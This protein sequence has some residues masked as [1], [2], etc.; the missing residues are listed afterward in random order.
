MHHR[1]ACAET[2]DLAFLTAKNHGVTLKIPPLHHQ[3]DLHLPHKKG[4]PDAHHLP[5]QLGNLAR[6]L[7]PTWYSTSTSCRTPLLFPVLYIGSLLQ[8]TSRSRL[9]FWPRWKWKELLPIPKPWSDPTTLRPHQH[10]P[11]HL[12]NWA[13]H[14]EDLVVADLGHSVTEVRAP[15]SL[16]RLH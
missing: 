1:N 8:L 2:T 3:D 9:W 10:A 5:P 11:L 13:C 15:D 6:M 4:S 14:A 7:L 16:V 12:D